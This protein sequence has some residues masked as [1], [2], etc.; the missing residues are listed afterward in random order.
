MIYGLPHAPAGQ[1][2]RGIGILL[3]KKFVRH[4]GGCVGSPNPEIF[5]LICTGRQGFP[6][7]RPYESR[8]GTCESQKET[9][10]AESNQ[11]TRGIGPAAGP[12]LQAKRFTQRRAWPGP[13]AALV[14]FK[15]R[16]T[17]NRKE[18]G[19]PA[20]APPEKERPAELSKTDRPGEPRNILKIGGRYP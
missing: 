8:N 20:H 7:V 18:K 9:E 1:V 4:R 13:K 19:D 15:N 5:H 17:Q 6:T 10:L 3:A 16:A 11:K 2:T 12:A 14:C